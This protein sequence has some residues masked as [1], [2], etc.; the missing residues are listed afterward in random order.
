MP[1]NYLDDVQLE[2]QYPSLAA[3]EDLDM[4]DLSRLED[5]QLY[6]AGMNVVQ[7]VLS[8]MSQIGRTRKQGGGVKGGNIEGQPTD[9]TRRQEQE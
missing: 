9:I 4:P 5:E 6:A 7:G 8:E 1:H 2:L 3:V